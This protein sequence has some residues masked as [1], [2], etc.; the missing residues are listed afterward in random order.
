MTKHLS[1]AAESLQFTPGF[2]LGFLHNDS[3]PSLDVETVPMSEVG[4]IC[5][6]IGGMDLRI[7]FFLLTL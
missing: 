4:R 3:S 7:R 5:I 6:I 2:S 1:E